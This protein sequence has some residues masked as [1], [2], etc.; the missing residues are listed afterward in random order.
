MEGYELSVD[1][2]DNYVSCGQS[3][4][5]IKN[6]LCGSGGRALLELLINKTYSKGIC[7]ATTVLAEFH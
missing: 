7:V 1:E 4:T 2:G 6:Y 3:V 5:T